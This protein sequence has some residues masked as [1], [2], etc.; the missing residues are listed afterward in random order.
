VA[1]AICLAAA[2]TATAA[3]RT[4]NGGAVP[5]GNWLT[6]GNWNGVA[7]TTDDVLVFT[8]GT[9]T[10]TTNNYSPGTPF[11]NVSFN[12]T[13]GAFS[14]NGNSLLL[15]SP[16]DAGSG[17]ITGGSISSA[18]ASTETIRTP[19]VLASGNHTISSSG[20]GT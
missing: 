11:N 13:A 4:W 5:D 10:A 7:P 17:L 6:A 12:A 14:L 8:G 3:T 16:T 18:S 9:Q 1:I 2:G 20:G 19:I 15:S